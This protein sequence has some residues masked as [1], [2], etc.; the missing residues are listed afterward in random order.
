M[1]DRNDIERCLPHAGAMVLL[2]AVSHWD[3]ASIQCSSAPLG[4]GHPLSRDGQLSAI[5]AVEYAAQAA[6]V[7]GALLD[8]QAVARAG[9]LAKLA[10]CDLLADGLAA[11][12]GPIEVRAGLLSRGDAGCLYEFSVSCGQPVVRGRLMVAFPPREPT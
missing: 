11:G 12:A 8:G 6:A 1:L 10:E 4:A 5:A 9:V 3:A 2:D 7:H